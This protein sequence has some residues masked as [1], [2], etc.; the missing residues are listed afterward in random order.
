MPKLTIQNPIKRSQAPGAQKRKA[1]INTLGRSEKEMKKRTQQSPSTL[2]WLSR[3][4]LTTIL[5]ALFFGIG[6]GIIF[7][8][9]LDVGDN[10]PIANVAIE[11]FVQIDPEP[12]PLVSVIVAPTLSPQRTVPKETSE[13]GVR[14]RLDSA[15]AFNTTKKEQW[16]ANAV[17]SPIIVGKPVIAIVIDDVGVDLKRARRSVALKGP[18]TIAI[19]TY[20]SNVTA[21]ARTARLN[22]HELIVHVPMEPVDLSANAGPNVLMTSH[23]SDELMRRLDW[24]LTRFVGYVGINN[25]MGSRFTAWKPGMQLVLAEINK[26]GLLYLDSRTSSESTAGLVARKL[27]L[28]FASRDVFLDNDPTPDAVWRQIIELEDIA[29]RHGYAVGIGHPHDATIAVLSEWLQDAEKRG[30]VLVPIS[31]IVQRRMAKS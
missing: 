20:A 29:N 17:N 1:Q 8:Y 22:G 16:L 21:L 9:W 12:S 23:D 6:L 14:I 18:L 26:R 30:F 31:A 28:P 11:E 15:P 4:L 27:N 7:G 5:P 10:F 19:M 2:M 24:A 13:T 25:H 3:K